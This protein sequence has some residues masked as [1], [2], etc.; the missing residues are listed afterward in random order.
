MKHRIYARTEAHDW[1]AG[2]TGANY[3]MGRCI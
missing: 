2:V 1:L 3:E